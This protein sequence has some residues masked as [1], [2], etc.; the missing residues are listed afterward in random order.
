MGDGLAMTGAPARI[1]FFAASQR[2]DDRDWPERNLAEH[3]S[4]LRD[5]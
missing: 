2:L 5:C 3:G 4:R 1:A